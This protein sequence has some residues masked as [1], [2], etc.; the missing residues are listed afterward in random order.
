MREYIRNLF[1]YQV[2]QPT[3]MVSFSLKDFQVQCWFLLLYNNLIV[4]YI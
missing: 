2:G 4:L 1:T 3:H